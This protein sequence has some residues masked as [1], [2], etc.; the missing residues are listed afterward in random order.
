MPIQDNETPPSSDS[1]D[2]H[3]PKIAASLKRYWRT[4]IK[5][6]AVLLTIWAIAGLGCGILFADSLN[7]IQFA[8]FRLGF[9]F[10]Q[11]GSIIIF[12][13]L[14]LAYA[15]LMNKLDKKHHD[16]LQAIKKEN[17]KEGK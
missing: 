16:E 12:V 10:A 13:L 2:L 17:V 3:D 14:V 7:E 15:I 6:T 4:N 8:G 5:I 1:P 11:Q 9:W